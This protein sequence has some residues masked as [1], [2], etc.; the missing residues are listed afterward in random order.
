MPGQRA[1]APGLVLSRSARD[2]NAAYRRAMDLAM[3]TLKENPRL[4]ILAGML[5][6]SQRGSATA[7]ERKMKLRRLCNCHLAGLRSFA[8]LY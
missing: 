7:R 6:T 5:P 2:A 8:A 1:L 3:A 4:G